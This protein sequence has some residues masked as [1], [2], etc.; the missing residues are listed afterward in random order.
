MYEKEYEVAVIGGGLCGVA[1][2]LSVAEQGRRVLLVEKR[3]SLGWEITSAFELDLKDIHLNCPKSVMQSFLSK[4]RDVGGL[5]NDCA[6]PAIVEMLLGRLV[7]KVKCGLLLYTRPVKTLRG[8]DGISG[9]VVGNKNGEM[10][11]RARI[12][13]DATENGFLWRETEV[14]SANLT[15]VTGRQSFFLNGVDEDLSLRSRLPGRPRYS[16]NDLPHTE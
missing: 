16:E 15:S 11:I 6:D 2:A 10:T 8:V 14:E 4:L 1:A 9:M 12:F 13:V 7:T 3:A 5:R